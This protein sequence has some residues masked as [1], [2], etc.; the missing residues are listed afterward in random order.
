VIVG[1]ESG[2]GFRPIKEDWVIDIRD[3][4]MI[5]QVPFFFK[6]W[7]G[8]NKKIKGSELQGKQYKQYPNDSQFITGTVVT[9]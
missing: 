2:P 5:N 7:G 4:C 3:L 8:T 1:G 6:Q 9:C